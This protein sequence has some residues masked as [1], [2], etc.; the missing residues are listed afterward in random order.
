MNR[1]NQLAESIRAGTATDETRVQLYEGILPFAQKIAKNYAGLLRTSDEMQDLLQEAYLAIQVAAETYDPAENTGF[2]TWAGFY[3]R[4]AFESYVGKQTGGSA[5]T[6]RKQYAVSKFEREFAAAFNCEPTDAEVCKHFSLTPEQ[7]QIL[8]TRGKEQSLNAPINEDGSTV[9]ED[10]LQ[11]PGGKTPEEVVLEQAEKDEVRRI[12]RKFIS[13]L[14]ADQR[15][16]VIR[17]Y[18]YGNGD[19]KG[20]ERMGITV[21]QFRT[22]RN[23]GIKSLRKARNIDTLQRYVPDVLNL[24]RRKRNPTQW[25][26]IWMVSRGNMTDYY[27]IKDD[28]EHTRRE[29]LKQYANERKGT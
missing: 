1:I 28:F 12:L 22:L 8:R 5:E 11:K 26:A 4:R 14:P 27:K 13:D 15:Q 10:L 23:K 16:A 9:L 18:L 2:L 7:L 25:A 20:A 17:F 3:I 6:V 24:Y 21:S 19:K 29:E